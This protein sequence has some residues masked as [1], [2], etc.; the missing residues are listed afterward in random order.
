MTTEVHLM[1]NLIE[2]NFDNDC[3]KFQKNFQK[4]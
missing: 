3:G 1:M 4:E 2:H